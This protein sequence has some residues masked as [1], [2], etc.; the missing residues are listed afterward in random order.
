[1]TRAAWPSALRLSAVVVWSSFIGAVLST[2]LL[3][4][5]APQMDGDGRFSLAI[6]GTWF[7]SYWVASLVPIVCGLALLAPPRSERKQ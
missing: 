4:L 2:A 5:V 3:L 1:M 7:L 6:L